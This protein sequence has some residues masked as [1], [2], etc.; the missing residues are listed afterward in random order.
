MS[1]SES[2]TCSD[3]RWSLVRAAKKTATYLTIPLR[4]TRDMYHRWTTVIPDSVTSVLFVCHGNICRSPFAASYFQFLVRQNGRPLTVRSAGLDTTPGKPA[5]SNTR[6]MARQQHLSLDDH[7]TTQLHAELVKQSDL[8]VVM[9]IA[10][11]IRVQ[12]LYPATKGSVVLLGYFDPHGPLEIADPYGRSL[13]DFR[14]CFEQ[15][16]RCCNGLAHALGVTHN[17]SQVSHT[18]PAP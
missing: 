5:H 15:V 9:E 16:T 13:D 1:V 17:R 4:M 10:Q 2:S 6:A 11:K 7:L 8:I 12:S 18:P 3:Q 14:I